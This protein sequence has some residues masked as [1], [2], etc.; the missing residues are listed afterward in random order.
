MNKEEQEHNDELLANRLSEQIRKDD[1]IFNLDTGY[2]KCECGKRLNS[3][4]HCPRCDY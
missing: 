4:G 3:H 2:E 1:F